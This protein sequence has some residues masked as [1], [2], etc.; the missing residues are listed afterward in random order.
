M[1]AHLNLQAFHGIGWPK[2]TEPDITHNGKS[3][4]PTL[5]LS[6]WVTVV[7]KGISVITTKLQGTNHQWQFLKTIPV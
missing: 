1:K 5:K 4:F 2:I 6:W 3:I 7:Y